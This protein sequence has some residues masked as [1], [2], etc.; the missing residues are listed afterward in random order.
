MGLFEQWPYTNFHNINLDSILEKI[1]DLEARV[2]ALE[3]AQ[4]A[5]EEE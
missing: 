5:Q 2:S 4:E 3:N 1:A